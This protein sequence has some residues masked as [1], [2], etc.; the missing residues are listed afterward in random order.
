MPYAEYVADHSAPQSV[1]DKILG[2]VE[3]QSD[4]CWRWPGAIDSTGYG[5]ISWSLGN[6]RMIYRPVHRVLYIALRGPIPAGLDLDHLCHDPK[7]CAPQPAS[8]CPHRRC[9]NPD[10]LDPVSRQANLLRGGTVVADRRAITHCPNGHPYTDANTLTSSS[11][12]RQ[13]KECTYERNRQYYWKN[14]ERRR[15]YN[16]EWR[17]Q[18]IAARAKPL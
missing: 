7:S 15:E 8:E 17:R 4:G 2:R 1:I 16:A 10:H 12:Q 13:C 5:R 11:N 6:R 18:R 3:L 9:C 14:R